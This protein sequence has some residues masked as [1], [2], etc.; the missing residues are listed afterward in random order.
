M[1]LAA[2]LGTRLRPLTDTVP[3]ALV[4]VGGVPMLE[5]VARRLVAAG[6]D[7]LIVNVHHHADQIERFI[8]EQTGFGVDVVVSR[9]TDAPLETGGGLLHAAPLIGREA[10]FFL[11]NVDVI[12]DIPLDE[13]YA[14]HLEAV[15]RAAGVAP[16]GPARPAQPR[17]PNDGPLATLAVHERDTHRFL[18]F[19]EQGLCGW[20]NLPGGGRPGE[21]LDARPA[22]GVVRRLAFAGIHVVEPRLLDLF[23]ERGAFSIVT[24]YVRLA[25]AGW[26]IR[27]HDVTGRAWL[28]I[29]D[30]ERLERARAW[31]RTR[32][33]D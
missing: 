22:V 12:T 19:D 21:R 11:H 4:Q 5:R 25:G 1:I 33:A 9:E 2:G 29:G 8:R 6:A 32:M 28:E 14:G 23:T 24:A 30:P 27:P 7:R 10:P 16:Q 20:E 15:D 13:L 26:T 3:K 17:T 31:A 18:L